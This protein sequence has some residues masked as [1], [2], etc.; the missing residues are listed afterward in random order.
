MQD[1]FRSHKLIG[2][3]GELFTAFELAMINVH[4]DLVKQDGTDIVA[5]KGP[6]II[7][8]QRIEVK[9]STYIDEKNCYCFSTSKGGQKKVYTKND[10]DILALVSL[11]QRNIRFYS[12]GLIKGMTKKIHDLVAKGTVDE[13]IVKSL[14]A[15]N[16]LSARSLGEQ[17]REWLK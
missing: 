2:M 6:G 9:A 7:L 5:I 13:H 12:V 17:V 8:A 10:C 11:P 15:K 16:E 4:C 1:N 3:A 14:K